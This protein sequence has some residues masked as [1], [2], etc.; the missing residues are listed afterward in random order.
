M[1]EDALREL[2]GSHA[3]KMKEE[4]VILSKD[5]EIIGDVVYRFDWSIT[6]PPDDYDVVI[7]DVDVDQ[8][9]NP[10]YNEDGSPVMMNEA[11]KQKFTQTAY[12]HFW[13]KVFNRAED[14][15]RDKVNW[16]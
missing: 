3:M 16:G 6:G 2:Y 1:T 9:K 10:F 4:E 7:E 8:I 15:V 11:D 13:K 12:D 14:R 5:P